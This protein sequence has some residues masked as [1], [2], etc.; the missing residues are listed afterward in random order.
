MNTG[1]DMLA[2]TYSRFTKLMFRVPPFTPDGNC[3]VRVIDR[4]GSSA[5]KVARLPS[6]E[7]IDGIMRTEFP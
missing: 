1:Q 2:F 6:F 3:F 7:H 5:L 4:G